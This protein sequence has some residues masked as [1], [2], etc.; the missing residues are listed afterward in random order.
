[1]LKIKEAVIVEGKY[2]KIKL[3]AVVDTLIIAVNGF[4][5]FKDKEKA[6]FI[7]QLADERGIIILTDSDDAGKLIRNRI[8]D[9][10]RGKKVYNAYVPQIYGKEKRKTEA[11][12][13]GFLGVEGIECELIEN[14]LRQC[15]ITGFSDPLKDSEK[16]SN[17]DLFRLGI[18]GK[19]N[20]KE[21]RTKVL[22]SLRLPANLSKNDLL[23]IL[24][25][26]F[27]LEE[28]EKYII[29]GGF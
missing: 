5:I 6:E 18:T 8:N 15:G 14:A 29:D 22:K 20:S 1:M 11:S 7:K 9:L 23:E 12:K 17:Y 3:S 21:M 27:T 10:V 19:E 16:I 24:Q 2:D 25:Y 28:F 4:G 26:R 13:Q